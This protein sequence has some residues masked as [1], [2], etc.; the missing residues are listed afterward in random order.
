[1]DDLQLKAIAE[2]P[3]GSGLDGF[4]ASFRVACETV[5]VSCTADAVERFGQEGEIG[6][7]SFVSNIF[8]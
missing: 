2:N 4:Y 7:S 3:I 8:L 1:M 6:H 5:G